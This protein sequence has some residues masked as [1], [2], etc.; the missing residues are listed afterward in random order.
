MPYSHRVQSPSPVLRLVAEADHARL[1]PGERTLHVVLELEAGDAPAERARPSLVTALAVDVSGSMRGDPLEHVVRSVERILTL[2]E[3]RD[4]LGVVAFSTGA[5]EVAPVARLDAAHRR[6]IRARIAELRADDRTNIEAG[7][8]LARATLPPRREGERQGIVLLSDGEPNVGASTADELSA[9]GRE[10]RAQAVVSTLGYGVRHD[11]VVLGAIADGGGGAYRFVPDPTVCQL[12]LAQAVGAQGD[13]AAE[14]IEL[15]LEPVPGVDIVSVLGASKPRYTAEGLVIS[16]PDMVAR[17]KRLVAVELR[18]RVDED[19]LRGELVD[20]CLRFCHAGESQR[21]EARARVSVDVGGV[22]AIAPGPRASVL[23][24]RADE[25]RAEA[26]RMADRGQFEGAAALLRA[27][28]QE[29]EAAPGYQAADGSPL[30]EAREQLLDEATAMERRPGAEAFATFKM[31]TAPKS[32]AAGDVGASSRSKSVMAARF[33][34]ATAGLFPEAYLRFVAGPRAG[35]ELRL[36]SQNTIGRTGS[37]DV[38]IP[39]DMVSRRHADVFALEGEFWIVDLC[40]TNTTRVNDKPLG[41]KPHKLKSG[42]R[43]LVGD[44]T[45]VYREVARG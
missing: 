21:R 42:D 14:S 37:A 28:M 8:R 3:D 2:L 16:V 32:F 44:T 1:S 17:A 25:A 20:V 40:S 9:I 23:L 7:L 41:T 27:L 30:S 36:G 45:L 39:S 10:L 38:V 13:V 11:D 4:Q 5:T 34:S 19:R 33:A 26:R 15:V 31:S 35:I 18:V 24:L 29:I 22:P 43:I 6:A 12:E